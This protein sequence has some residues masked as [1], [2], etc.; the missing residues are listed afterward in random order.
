MKSML[1]TVKDCDQ[2]FL[3]NDRIP[4]K[5]YSPHHLLQASITFVVLALILPATAEQ[6]QID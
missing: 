5:K 1:P 4:Q 2:L 3:K 6:S